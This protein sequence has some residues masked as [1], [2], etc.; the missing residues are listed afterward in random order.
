MLR[1]IQEQCAEAAGEQGE[2]AFNKEF[3]RN[4]NVVLAVKKKDPVADRV[5]QFVSSFILCTREKG[6]FS[7]AHLFLP[8]VEH[9]QKID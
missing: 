6:E 1:K 2:E 9:E 5:I 7:F 8:F 4:L 3:I